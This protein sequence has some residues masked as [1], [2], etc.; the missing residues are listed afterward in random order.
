MKLPAT[1]EEVLELSSKYLENHGFPQRLG[2]ID[3]THIEIKQPTQGYTDYLN[4]KGRY[5]LNEQTI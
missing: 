4:R 5:S 1:E 3:G 2:A